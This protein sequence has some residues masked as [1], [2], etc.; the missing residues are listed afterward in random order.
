MIASTKNGK[1]MYPSGG[2]PCT[3]SFFKV[4]LSSDAFQSDTQLEK[5]YVQGMPSD[6]Y[7]SL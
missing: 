3:S 7:I 1:D 6:G 5:D 2:I 4:L